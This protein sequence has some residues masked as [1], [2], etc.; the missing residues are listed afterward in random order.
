MTN[1]ATPP[2]ATGPGELL[3]HGLKLLLKDTDANRRIAMICIDNS[4]ELMMK[5]FLGLPHRISGIHITRKDYSDLSE[6][7]PKLLDGI[8][9]YASDKIK[10]IDLGEIEWF[11]RLR[12]ELYHQGNG[13]TVDR[14]NV[15]VYAEI[16]NLLFLNLFGFKLI[17]DK[18]DKTDLL[19]KFMNSWIQFE[20]MVKDMSFVLDDNE[21]VRMPLDAIRFLYKNKIISDSELAT[22]DSIR[23]TRNEIVHGNKNHETAINEQMVKDLDILTEKIKKRTLT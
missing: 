17:E 10:G 5:T 16:A 18:D 20:K 12:N 23:R 22:L 14:N 3:G 8:E 4:V 11:H 15:E 6:N 13:L 2:W 19:G 21:K 1:K 9:K 7:Y